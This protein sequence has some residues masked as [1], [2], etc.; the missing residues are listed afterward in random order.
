MLTDVP[1]SPYTAPE[2]LQGNKGVSVSKADIFSLGMLINYSMLPV[3]R[4]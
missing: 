2:V 4:K 3:G 1:V